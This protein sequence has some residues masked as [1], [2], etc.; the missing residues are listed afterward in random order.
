MTPDAHRPTAGTVDRADDRAGE[1]IEDHRT[2]DHRRPADVCA[3]PHAAQA[4]HEHRVTI[5]L[6]Q[7]AQD[8]ARLADALDAAD[9]AVAR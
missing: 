6:R 2:D 1:L 4:L 3:D 5:S 7:V 9:E 8:L